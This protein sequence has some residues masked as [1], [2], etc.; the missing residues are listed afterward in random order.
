MPHA[1]IIGAGPA[2]CVASIILARAGW[3]VAL[4][5]QHR[6][7]RDKVCGECLSALGIGVLDRL[8]LGAVH[9]ELRAIELNTAL[10]HAPNG[11]TIDIDLPSA[12]LGVSRRSFDHFL[13]KAARGSGARLHQPARCERFQ[14]NGEL[15]VEVRDLASNRVDVL[16]PDWLLVADGKGAL[17]PARPSATADFGIKAHFQKIDGPRDAIELFGVCGC[18]G[19]LAPIEDGKWNAAFSV[20]Q[21]RLQQHCGD[22]DQL[23]TQIVDENS[24]LRRRMHG[25][26]RVTQW[27]ASPLPRFAVTKNWPDRVVPIGNAAAAIEPIGGEGMGLAMRSAEMASHMLLESHRNGPPPNRLALRARFNRLWR[28]RRFACRV[29]ALAVSSSGLTNF[30]LPVLDGRDPLLEQFMQLAGKSG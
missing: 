29:A 9:D 17:L 3:D 8:G 10:L 2:G 14:S 24:V 28:T 12:M 13:L 22:V 23:F 26:R 27:L 5:E 6:F 15:R 30:A 20:P 19:G 7:P 18:Y 16:Q 25:A 21:A 4:I 1:A 11:S